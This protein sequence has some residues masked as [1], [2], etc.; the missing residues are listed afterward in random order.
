[1]AVVAQFEFAGKG[2]GV[3]EGATGVGAQA[4]VVLHGASQ[5]EGV[6]WL[7]GNGEHAAIAAG[8]EQQLA[9]GTIGIEFVPSFQDGVGAGTLLS[10]SG[11]GVENTGHFSLGTTASGQVIVQHDTAAAEHSFRTPAGFF[12]NGDALSASYSW[13]ASGKGGTF[14]V[15]NS[16]TGAVHSQP[17]SAALTMDMGPGGDAPWII[18]A[19]TAHADTGAATGSFQGTV[20]GFKISDSVDNSGSDGIVEGTGGDDLIDADYLGDPDGDRIDHRDAV[21]PGAQPNDDYVLA[22]DGNDTVFGGLGRDQIFGEDGDDSIFG[23]NGNDTIDGGAG[24]DTVVGGWGR[25]V[26]YGGAGNDL[27]DGGG[28]NDDDA[29]FIDG[30]TGDDTLTGGGGA[31]T[32]LGGDDRDV[33]TGLRPGGFVDGGEGGVDFDT[34]DLSDWGASAT[35]IIYDATNPENGVVEFLDT[36]GNIVGTLTFE[37]IENVVPCFTPGTVIATPKGERPVE[38][39]VVGDKIVTRDNGIQ[40]IRWVGAKA[41]TY[42]ELAASEHLRPILI[43]RGSLGHDLP[44]RDMMVSPNHRVLVANERTAL[45]FEEHEVLVAA[46]HL[47][48][49]HRIRDVQSLGTTYIHFMF[50]H[51]EV[52]LANGCWTESFQPGDYSL[53][54]LGNAQRGEIYEL[55]PELKTGEGRQKYTAAR[56]TL[57]RHEAK[58]LR[59]R[60]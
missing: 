5:S 15:V 26:I 38:E 47:V 9:T 49:N 34:L 50:D 30:G 7:G 31:D 18:G 24:D 22:G 13:D 16:A 17:I 33:F 54:G 58:L 44:E 2:S 52:V 59:F 36:Y 10:R 55:F 39:L 27:L 41:L 32:L 4:G 57:K 37:N 53:N 43:T 51:H 40:E 23:G 1:M 20:S 45:Y 46:K 29:D 56:K 60:G 8:P 25:D 3:A 19:P 12:A 42:G 35:N 11:S 48:D 21:L 14:A 6:L 28:D